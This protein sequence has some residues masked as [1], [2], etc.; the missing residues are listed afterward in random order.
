MTMGKC[1]THNYKGS[2]IIE[3]PFSEPFTF[4]VFHGSEFLGKVTHISYAYAIIN[5]YNNK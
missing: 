3:N 1:V 2:L 5:A 4:L